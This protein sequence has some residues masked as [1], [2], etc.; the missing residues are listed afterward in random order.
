MAELMKRD[1][2]VER[3]SESGG[4]ISYAEFSYSLL[5]GYDHWHL[6]KRYGVVLQIGGSDQWGN[7]LS[8]VSLIR[9][10]EG[11][12]AHAMSMPLVVNKSTGRK[13]GKTEGGA[14]WL[15]AELTPPAEFYQFWLN[16]DDASAVDYLKI[17]TL[18]SRSEIEAVAEELKQ[19][20]SG[21]A[22][23]RRLA[24]EVACLVHG[25]AAAQSAADYA[26]TLAD[27]VAS[28]SPSE[29]KAAPGDNIVD[30]L[31]MSG[32]AAS[33]TEARQLLVSGGVYLNDQ[34]VTKDKIAAEDFVGGAL[35]L[36]R[37]KKLRHTA[38]FALKPKRQ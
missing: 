5:Q 20:P 35:K 30:L 34:P 22:A 9:K 29:L 11:Q 18:L 38:F 4:G 1:F 7:L 3:L 19:N 12:E 24:Y 16:V 23:Q 15:D 13:F 25:D 32:L 2:V 27:G 21:R 28:D 31:V 36:R 8:G 6:F 17:Y 10:K 14:I 37:G 33:K 26:R